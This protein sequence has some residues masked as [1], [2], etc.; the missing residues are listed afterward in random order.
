MDIY[1]CGMGLQ[2]GLIMRSLSGLAVKRGHGVLIAKFNF[3]KN[4][5]HIMSPI[6]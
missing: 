2:E 3:I 5:G 4:R 6:Y 1:L